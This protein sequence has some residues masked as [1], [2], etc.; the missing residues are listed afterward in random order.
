[1]TP[2]KL[3]SR[4][5]DEEGALYQSLKNEQPTCPRIAAAK[6]MDAEIRR[7]RDGMIPLLPIADAV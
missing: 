2:V 6:R 3:G 5:Y 7:K 1:M 4:W